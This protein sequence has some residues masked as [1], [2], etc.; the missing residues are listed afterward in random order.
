MREDAFSPRE[1]E[2]LLL[3]PVHQRASHSRGRAGG[4]EKDLPT[5][6]AAS[7]GGTH[8]PSGSHPAWAGTWRQ[9]AQDKTQ[10]AP[11]ETPPEVLKHFH[12]QERKL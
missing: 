1:R 7:Q 9:K 11:Q 4:Q 5:R 6:A 12:R 8:H 2:L 3:Q 10:E